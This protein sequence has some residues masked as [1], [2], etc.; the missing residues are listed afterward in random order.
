MKVKLTG[1]KQITISG[2]YIK[3]DGFLKFASVV[4]TGGEAKNLIQNGEVF[5]GGERCYMRGK[6]LRPGDVIR[7]GNESF[8]IGRTTSAACEK[9]CQSNDRG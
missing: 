2:E 1:I 7:Y 9:P 5:V 3:L 4:S 6:K 8:I